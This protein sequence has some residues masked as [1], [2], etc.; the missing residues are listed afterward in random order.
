MFMVVIGAVLL[1][2]LVIGL[3]IFSRGTTPVRREQQY[4]DRAETGPSP[5]AGLG[6]AEFEGLC[7]RL[8]EEMGLIVNSQS[9]PHP[10]E[11]EITAVNPQP[12][13]G[14]DY[15]I[16]GIH[17]KGDEVVDAGQVMALASAVKGEQA[18]KGILITTGYFSEDAS[19]LLEGPPIEMINRPRLLE[20]IRDYGIR[21]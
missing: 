19:R 6:I 17:P 3:L 2:F 14:G 5:F 15:I 18:S 10:R 7:L 8:I 4:Y 11:V 13:T 1:G 16:H 21:I 9:R 20:L 12:I